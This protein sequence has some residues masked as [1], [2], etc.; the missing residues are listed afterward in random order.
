VLD[1]REYEVVRQGDEVVVVGTIRDPVNW[2]F[3]IRIS[4]DDIPGTARMLLSPAMLGMLLRAILKPRKRH[5][6]S[7]Q[8]AEHL[9]EGKRRRQ[10]TAETAADRARACR[11][12]VTTRRRARG[13]QPLPSTAGPD[14][15]LKRPAADGSS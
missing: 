11:E 15:G 6:W 3:T 10:A 9:A 12:T 4:E 7:Q 14:R 5:H 13:V 1:F 2:D 8:R